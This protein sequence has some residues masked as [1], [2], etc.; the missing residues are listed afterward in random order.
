MSAFR[1]EAARRGIQAAARWPH[2]SR[3]S[4]SLPG[5]TGRVADSRPDSC[6]EP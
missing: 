5:T 3:Y 6:S 4:S 1:S 2:S